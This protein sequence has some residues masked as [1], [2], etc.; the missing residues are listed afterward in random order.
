LP[1]EDASSLSSEQRLSVP[2]EGLPRPRDATTPAYFEET[3][4]GI[5]DNEDKKEDESDF[6]D[7][8]AFLLA[9][10][11]DDKSL[12]NGD[13]SINHKL[14]FIERLMGLHLSAPSSD[15]SKGDEPKKEQDMDLDVSSPF[16]KVNAKWASRMRQFSVPL[17]Q[18]QGMQQQTSGPE[19]TNPLLRYAAAAMMTR[20]LAAAAR[21]NHQ[22]PIMGKDKDDNNENDED[23]VPV[24][25]A[26]MRS[27]EEGGP[28]GGMRGIS[29]SMYGRPMPRPQLRS[30]MVNYQLAQQA[31]M[32]SHS[33]PQR[34]F[35]SPP[36]I[37]RPSLSS[38]MNTPMQ[39]VVIMLAHVPM[40]Q[41]ESRM[42]PSIS[43]NPYGAPQQS[44]S[45]Y[46]QVSYAAPMG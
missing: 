3:R 31:R 39:P 6:N 21:A 10:N 7:H 33:A 26:T 25:L 27:N 40:Q 43:V 35:S 30:P 44:S 32:V 20:L 1:L 29:G 17:V 38:S 16:D 28:I 22:S 11:D 9:N 4:I 14:V 8:P 37:M 45:Y 5:V 18:E 23:T 12:E 41:S 15:E 46:P 24:L 34:T 36:G 2:G 13:D 19:Q 42:G